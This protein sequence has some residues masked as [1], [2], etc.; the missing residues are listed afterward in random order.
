MKKKEIIVVFAIIIVGLIIVFILN[1]ALTYGRMIETIISKDAWLNFWGSYCGGLF[2]VAVGYLAIIHSNR[3]NEKAINQQYVL[4]KHQQNEKKLD[5]YNLCLRNNL[6]LMNAVE[7]F[8]PAISMNYDNLSVTKSEIAKKK[9][10]IFSYDLQYRYVFEIDSNNN[11]TEIESKYD[12]CWIESRTLLSDIL[13]KQLD[14]VLRVGQNIAET[15]MKRN[16][17]SILSTLYQLLSKSGNQ[18]EY[19]RYQQDIANTTFELERLEKSI[20]TYKNDVD[21]MNANLKKSLDLLLF[22][23]KELFDLSIVLMKEKQNI[24]SIMKD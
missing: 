20:H 15:E 11:K 19:K 9:S 12:K 7:A 1:Y 23:A 5:E 14:F 8:R 13:D 24:Y 17:Q 4:L 6:E 22:K 21:N 2:A 16:N 18:D 10:L 3:N